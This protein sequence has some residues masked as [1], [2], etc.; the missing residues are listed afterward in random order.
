MEESRVV[1]TRTDD[2]WEAIFRSRARTS[3]IFHTP[4]SN[5]DKTLII[6]VK[7]YLNVADSGSEISFWSISEFG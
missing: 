2:G 7:H 6:D 4:K 3:L 1:K 5:S